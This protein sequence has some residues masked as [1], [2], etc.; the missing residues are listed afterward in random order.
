[1]PAETAAGISAVQYL[2]FMAET[3]HV[4]L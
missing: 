3:W 2:R 4:T 1:V